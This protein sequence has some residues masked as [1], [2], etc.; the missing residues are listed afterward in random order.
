MDLE[1]HCPQENM[2]DPL[3]SKCMLTEC[4]FVLNAVEVLSCSH[5]ES[6]GWVWNKPDQTY[7][8][9]GGRERL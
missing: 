2:A 6:I 7:N 9:Q 1:C 8:V 5:T 3:N 4:T